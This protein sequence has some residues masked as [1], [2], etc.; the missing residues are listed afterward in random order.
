MLLHHEC[1]AGTSKPRHTSQR[2]H[3]ELFCWHT[4]LYDES[5]LETS[6]YEDV[7]VPARVELQVGSSFHYDLTWVYF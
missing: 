4:N 6:V 7:H 1:R 3:P 2:W 5:T